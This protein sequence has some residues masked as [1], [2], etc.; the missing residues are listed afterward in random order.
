LVVAWQRPEVVVDLVEAADDLT[1]AAF[2]DVKTVG[3]RHREQ[4]EY[5]SAALARSI[6]IADFLKELHPSLW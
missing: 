6:G 5:L 4:G 3:G 2:V 1:D